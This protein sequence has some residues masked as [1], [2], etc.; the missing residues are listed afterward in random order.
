[1]SYSV[2]Q[3]DI[4]GRIGTGIGKGLSEQVPKELERNRLSSAL[5]SLGEQE[6][7]T[8]Y[9]QFTGLVGAAHEYPQVVQ[10]GAELL[11]HQGQR[12]AYTNQR[13]KEG[14]N[15]F[16]SQSLSNIDFANLNQGRSSTSQSQ[17]NLRSEET[18]P[19]GNYPQGEPQIVEKNPLSPELQS[20]IPWTP[21]QRDEEIGHVWDQNPYLTR[22]EVLKQVAD[23]ER[24][25]LEAPEAYKKQQADLK[26]IQTQVN[27]E[28]DSQLRKKLQVPKDQDVWGKLSGES[29]NRIERGV[30][31]DLRKNPNANVN[32]LV[33]TWTD[34][35]LQNDKQKN[36]LSTLANRSFGEK[37]FKR[38]ENLEKL[39]SIGK[40]FKEFGNSEEYY[41]ILRSDFGASPEGA[42]SIAY[43]LSKSAENYINNIKES[44]AINYNKNA[45]KYAN[46]L[47]DYLTRGDS[48]LSISKNIKEKDPFFDIKTF[49]SEVR[50]I[51]DELGLTGA[52]KLEINARGI[53][54]IFPNWG[55]I[56][57]FPKVGKGL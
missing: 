22:D 10:S 40:S 27:A 56:F 42:A 44:N 19:Q 13:G 26:E 31:R 17:K 6:G 38:Q 2:K 55:D 37:L 1:M 45:M 46:E 20:G 39:K 7:L 57:L 48:I 47:G 52:Q 24:R 54:D 35:A 51:E 9:Q 32:D 34:R 23:N 8:P 43:P 36:E 4:F 16:P 5:K 50:K 25:Y 41:N 15:Q 28:I 29:Q 53:Q 14:N 11:R 30:S 18:I 49:L 33:N 21:Q 3:G 12:Q